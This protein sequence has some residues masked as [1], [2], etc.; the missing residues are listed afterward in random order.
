MMQAS[1]KAEAG[2][3]DCAS[4]DSGNALGFEHERR[5]VRAV[6][7]LRIADLWHAVSMMRRSRQEPPP[8]VDNP[9]TVVE[10]TTVEPT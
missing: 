3:P 9:V 10:F 2:N 8:Q 7:G 4:T 5:L 6:E 1:S